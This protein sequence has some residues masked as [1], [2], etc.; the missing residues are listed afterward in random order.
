L[1][2]EAPQSARQRL[3][4]TPRER[5]VEIALADLSRAHPELRE[6]TRRVDV[7]ANGHAMVRPRPGLI[8]G[9]ARRRVLENR[10]RIHFAHADLSGLSL[11]EE[12]NY[13]GVVGAERVLERL[14]V[15]TP[16]MA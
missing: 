6:I 7:W 5:W 14:G 2:G 11:F 10:G 3:L 1:S 9:N 4:V 16:S 12:A 8:W 15:R 13:R